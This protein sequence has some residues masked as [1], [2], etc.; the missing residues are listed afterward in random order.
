MAFSNFNEIR[1]N[2]GTAG[3]Q[4]LLKRAEVQNTGGGGGQD[5]RF[6]Q[7]EVDK[8]GN[9]SAVIR[10]LDSPQ[11]ND[12]PWVRTFNHGF[13]SERSGKWFIEECPTTVN[14]ECP[15]CAANN[16]LWETGVKENQDIVRQRKR[17]LHYISNILV[18]KDPKNPENEGKVKLFKYGKKI[19]DK[20][21]D[22]MDPKF[23]DITP[24]Q[25]FDFWEGANF[26]LR[27][28]KV[29]GYRNYDKS[30]FDV[31]SA[32]SDD[33]SEVESIW[34]Q[35]HDLRP[36]IDPASFK[37]FDTLK[38][39]FEAV[40]SN[41]VAQKIPSAQEQALSEMESMVDSTPEPAP[42]RAPVE[43]AE[44][45]ARKV[46]APPPVAPQAGDDDDDE[47]K[48]FASLIDD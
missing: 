4:N 23:D 44:I 38:K 36:F 25:P 28:C 9:G 24:L 12:I 48:Y 14:Q 45:P 11:D 10:F 17:K 2:R 15:V 32:I 34:K 42:R 37:D 30:E 33:D 26:K 18:I 20:I 35:E 21:M 40:V 39:R 43:R 31:P 6:W 13:K 7:P 41:S 8:V 1:K 16:E 29:E 5:D 3:L 19:Y 22:A 46:Q 27:I 47:A